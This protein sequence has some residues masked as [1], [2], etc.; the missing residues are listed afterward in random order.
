MSLINISLIF[1]AGVNVGL[2]ILIWLRNPNNKI[3]INLALSA[4][5]LGLWSFSE[6]IFREASTIQ[7]AILWG[8]LENIFGSLVV[9]FFFFFTLYFPYQHKKLNYILKSLILVSLTALYL[10]ILSPK[11][12]LIGVVLEPSNND[13]ILHP[14][15]RAYYALYFLAYLPIAF[16]WLIRKY[17]KSYGIFRKNILSIIFATGFMSL[18]GIIFGIMMPLVLG[19]NNPWY[20]PYFSIPMAI[21]LAYVVFLSDKKISI[22]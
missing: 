17:I 5:A 11:F 9:L 18:F 22:K 19:R 3:N 14:V 2:A 7:N 15:G 12:Y 20:A 6:A 8:R 1:V 4:L 21:I 13:F 16:Y 10:I